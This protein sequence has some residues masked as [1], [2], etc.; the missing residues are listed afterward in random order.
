MS[1]V[2]LLRL[3]GNSPTPKPLH[4]STL[5]RVAVNFLAGPLMLQRSCSNVGT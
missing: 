3:S 2:A 1:W 5:R 4:A